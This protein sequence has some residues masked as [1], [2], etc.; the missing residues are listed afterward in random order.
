M[1]R[2]T[3]VLG[4][5]V[6]ALLLT[7]RAEAAVGMCADPTLRVNAEMQAILQAAVQ[8]ADRADRAEQTSVLLLPRDSA[9]VNMATDPWSFVASA[10]ED[11]PAEDAPWCASPDDPRCSPRGGGAP[12]GTVDGRLPIVAVAFIAFAPALLG[13]APSHF[14]RFGLGPEAGVSYRVERPP[15]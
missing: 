9:E 6:A 7:G 5:V 10:L 14:A 4:M 12:S 2:L 8:A 13:E 3:T 1:H 11:I 15:R